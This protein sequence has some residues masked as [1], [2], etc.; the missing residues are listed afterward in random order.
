MKLR[1]D[2]YNWEKQNEEF[3]EKEKGSIYDVDVVNH[4]PHYTKG[5]Y[6]TIDIIDDAVDKAPTTQLACAQG[7]VIKYILRMWHKGKALEDAKKAKWYLNKMIKDL[8]KGN[9]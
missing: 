9:S 1:D 2:L 5:K 6:E 8:E 4:P 7:N 3:W